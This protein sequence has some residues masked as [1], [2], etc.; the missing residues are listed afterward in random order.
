MTFTVQDLA[1]KVR[2]LAAENPDYIYQPPKGTIGCK[3]AEKTADGEWVGSCIVGRA[4]IA[5][6]INPR[7]FEDAGYN[8]SSFGTVF[9]ALQRAWL[10]EPED[11]TIEEADPYLFVQRVQSHQ[12]TGNT[13][14]AECVRIADEKTPR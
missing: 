11:V 9:D 4:L 6:G 12:D 14:W 2:E 13:R 5:L 10:M 3:N 1:A 7:W 8:G